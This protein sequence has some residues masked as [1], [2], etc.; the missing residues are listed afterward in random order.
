MASAQA[1]NEV[2]YRTLLTELSVVIK[3]YL[4]SRLGGYDFTDDCTQEVLIAIHEARHTYDP[5]K[6]FR[7]WLFAIIR[8]K[9]IDAIRRQRVRRDHQADQ[10][11][12][13][14]S[15]D[16]GTPLEDGV[17]SGQLIQALSPSHREAIKLTKILGFT[18]AEAASRLSISE[19]AMKVR[20]HRATSNLR[21]LMEAEAL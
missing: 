15:A 13:D 5:R 18:T 11:V 7:P 12:I 4:V 14:E 6:K 16:N 17:S 8:H 1:G 2:D 3:R 19:S 9:S 20:V 21:K 10:C